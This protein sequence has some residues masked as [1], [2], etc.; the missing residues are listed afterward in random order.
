MVLAN[1]AAFSYPPIRSPVTQAD[2]NIAP[3]WVQ[4]FQYLYTRVGGSTG[5]TLVTQETGSYAAAATGA[6]IVGTVAVAGNYVKIGNIVHW[7]VTIIPSGGSSITSTLGTT[8][9][10][11]PFIA[12]SYGTLTAIDT[13][14]RIS[15]GTGQVDAATASAY[16]PTWT[17]TG[18]P[19]FINGFYQTAS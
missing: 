11:L 1:P 2:G 7:S 4:W 10:T 5:N 16:V 13:S 12:Q 18:N 6:V 3:V 15:L 8:K 17:A 14:T 9:L 19:V